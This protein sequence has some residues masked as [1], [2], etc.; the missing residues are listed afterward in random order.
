MRQLLLIFQ[1]FGEPEP[2]VIRRI[3]NIIVSLSSDKFLN[4]IHTADRL[5]VLT[6]CFYSLAHD[7]QSESIGLV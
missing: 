6:A 7:G 5:L 2:K 4:D 3:L 1:I